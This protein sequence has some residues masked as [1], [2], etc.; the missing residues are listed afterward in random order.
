[1]LTRAGR[2]RL[3]PLRA[4][5]KA[6]MLS[7]SFLGKRDPA[8]LQNHEPINPCSL[9]PPNLQCSATAA[10]ASVSRA[11]GT[12]NGPS[13]QGPRLLQGSKQAPGT[14]PCLH[15]WIPTPKSEWPAPRQDQSSVKRGGTL[16]LSAKPFRFP[17]R[18]SRVT[19]AVQTLG[20]GQSPPNRGRPCC[21]WQ[22][23]SRWQPE[24]VGWFSLV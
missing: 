16:H 12:G 5:K 21:D 14:P 7:Q 4:C 9:K 11:K 13:P 15:D 22:V 17:E 2:G 1:M 19:S 23:V 24:G 3:P 18:D 8:C 10:T 20:S 6:Q